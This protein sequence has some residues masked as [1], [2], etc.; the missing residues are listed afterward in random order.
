VAVEAVV[1]EDQE[2]DGE[3][4]AGLAGSTAFVVEMASAAPGERQPQERGHG[5]HRTAAGAVP[6]GR[7]QVRSL[8]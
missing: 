4:A 1:E 7:E 5:D 6:G 2:G 8:G 3:E